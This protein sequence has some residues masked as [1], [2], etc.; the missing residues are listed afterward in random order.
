MPEETSVPA[1]EVYSHG[2]PLPD[3]TGYVL[4]DIR[5]TRWHLFMDFAHPDGSTRTL[6][7]SADS[8]F[9]DNDG[10]WFGT[11]DAWEHWDE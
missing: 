1:K 10:I 2:A 4:T 3:I 7:A 11:G 9:T 8:F 5:L 6:V